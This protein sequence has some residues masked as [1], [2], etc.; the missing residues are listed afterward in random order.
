M[1]RA[2]PRARDKLR[3]AHKLSSHPSRPIPRTNPSPANSAVSFLSFVKSD[4]CLLISLDPAAQL[5]ME[6]HYSCGAW[7]LIPFP[8]EPKHVIIESIP[9]SE[10]LVITA[11]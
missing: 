10:N 11:A 6:L 7:H 2:R 1:A 8:G 4:Y 3:I 5:H 9:P